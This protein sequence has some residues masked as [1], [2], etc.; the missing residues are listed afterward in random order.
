MIGENNLSLELPAETVRLG[1][2]AAKQFRFPPFGHETGWNRM[3]SVAY[4][5]RRFEFM[6]FQ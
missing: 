3:I 4:T 1:G 2:P 5:R 6:F